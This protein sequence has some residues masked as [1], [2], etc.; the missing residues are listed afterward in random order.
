MKKS[1]KN[2]VLIGV[3]VIFIAVMLMVTIVVSLI[4]NRQNQK[5]A[6]TLLQNAFNLVRYTI[7]ERQQKLLY[8]SHQMAS[9]DDMPRKVKYVM[10]SSSYFEYDT[11]RP[12][13]IKM[14][15]G[16]HNIGAAADI[17]KTGIYSSEGSLMAFAVI[18][19]NGNTLGCVHDKKTIEVASLKPKEELTRDSWTVRDDLP[20]DIQH[21]FDGTVANGEAIHFQIVDDLLCLVAYIPIMGKQYN[22]ETEKMEV[23]QVGMVVTVQKLG[24]AFAK[25]MAE[26]SG[27][28]INIYASNNLVAGTYEDYKSFDLGKFKN[29]ESGC[30]LA[31]STVTFNSIDLDDGSYFQG[32]LP[33]YHNSE[34]I[35]AITT[36]YSKAVAK[37]NTA[38]IIK[39][40]SLVYLLGIVLV[41]PIT[42]L[43]VVRGIIKPI[44]TIAAMMRRVTLKKD[45]TR[46]LNIHTQDEIGDLALS[47]NQ[48]VEDLNNTTVSRDALVKE[49]DERKNIQE[50]LVRLLSLHTATLESTADGLLVVDLEGHVTSYNEKFLQMWQISEETINTKDD[51]KLLES[52][53]DQLEDPQGFLAE[54]KRLYANINEQSHDFVKFKDNRVFERVSLPQKIDDK[55]LGRV[56]SFRDVTRQKNTEQ[57]MKQLNNDLEETIGKV[58]EAN[59]NLKRFVYVASHDLREPLRKITAFGSI[60]KDSIVDKIGEDD[61]E[62]LNYMIDGAERMSQMIEGLLSY[63]RVSTKAKPSETVDLD[64][65]LKQLKELE[66]AVLIEEKNVTVEVPQQMPDV[67][68]DPVQLRQLLQNL[69][70]NGI[71]YQPKDTSPKITVTAR[72]TDND[73]V[74]V[75]VTDN[76]IGIKPEDKEAVFE[77]FRRLHS[78][79]EYEGTG[80]GLAVC[81]KIVE[82]HG[83]QIGVES[84]YGKG[85]TFWFTVPAA[86]KPVEATA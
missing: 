42:I 53:L 10:E 39:L 52:A 13:Y 15:S 11:L 67:N 78:R 16:I 70:A 83:G 8:D 20:G 80:I 81:K 85:S 79:N 71:K 75:E 5:A 64:E 25:K 14:A 43:M 68:A 47:F 65:V 45:F 74:R 21:S 3:P 86:E 73:M 19:E 40:M 54:V 62:N 63:S 57:T 27:T 38:Q 50:E 31:T 24:A 37:A 4:L 34:C 55:V 56:W 60:L 82:R 72:Q 76:G 33:I 32:I 26:L 36:L 35:A 6:N 2:K 59:D 44:E 12:T 84:E 22:P 30:T 23:N 46:K 29:G 61:V 18:E 77:M 28:N 48:M 1:L 69:I 49:V 51:K 58:E 7:S 9:I 66:L 41:V 17:W